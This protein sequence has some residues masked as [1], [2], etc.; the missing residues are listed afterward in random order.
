MNLT[1]MGF[2][3]D[4]TKIHRYLNHYPAEKRKPN[5]V[6][7]NNNLSFLIPFII[8]MWDIEWIGLTKG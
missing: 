6:A 4:I 3:V 2:V 5:S 7:C 1:F 8:A